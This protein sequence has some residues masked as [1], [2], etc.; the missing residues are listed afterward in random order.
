MN[1]TW[2]PAGEYEDPALLAGHFVVASL[3]TAVPSARMT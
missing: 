1:A 2:R 3:V